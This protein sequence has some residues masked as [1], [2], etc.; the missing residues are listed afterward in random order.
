MKLGLHAGYWGL[1]I[2]GDS[3][4]G[5]KDAVRDRLAAY[6]DAGVGTLL[7]MPTAASHDERRRM[8]RDL[9]EIAA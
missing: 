4:G 5:T 3:L 9:A 1:G 6:R 2:T 8:L 7:V